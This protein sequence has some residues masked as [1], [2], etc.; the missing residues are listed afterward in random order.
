[1]NWNTESTIE[2][3]VLGGCAPTAQTCETRR[4]LFH[5]K[6]YSDKVSVTFAQL[7]VVD[8]G[9]CLYDGCYSD[10]HLMNLNSSKH[11]LL[12]DKFVIKVVYLYLCPKET[13]FQNEFLV[14]KTLKV[15]KFRFVFSVCLSLSLSVSLCLPLSFCITLSLKHKIVLKENKHKNII[16]VI[17][18]IEW[19]QEQ[20]WLIMEFGGKEHLEQFLSQ[21]P[22]RRLTEHVAI[23]LYLQLVSA[24]DHLHHLQIVHRDIKPENI[25]VEKVKEN[26]ENTSTCESRFLLKLIDFGFA[27][28]VKPNSLN[29]KMYCTSNKGKQ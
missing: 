14:S 10:I 3:E 1:M 29:S 13:N 18:I 26:E 23:N 5:S 17:D 16:E 11:K 7:G 27:K 20:F 8:Y 15:R 21:Q 28:P 19:S 24:L 2:P 4:R 25:M 9:C 6:L 22:E 12:S